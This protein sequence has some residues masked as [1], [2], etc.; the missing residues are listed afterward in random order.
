MSRLILILLPLVLPTYVIRFQIGPLPTT[1]LEVFLLAFLALWTTQRGLPGWKNARTLLQKRGW[2]WPLGLW[3]LAGLIG[4]VVAQ[5]HLAALGL[6][7]AY[8]LEPALVFAMLTDLV[9]DDREKQLLLRSLSVTVAVLALWAIA[10]IAGLLPIPTPW[11]TPPA[12]LRAT[13]P[14]PFPNALALFVVPATALF[15]HLLTRRVNDRH[16]IPLHPLWSVIGFGSGIIATVLAKSD[17][18]LIALGAAMFLSLVFRKKSR[19]LAV[20]LVVIAAAFLLAR[21]S[22]RTELTNQFLFR[23]WSGK[24]RLVMWNET[25]EM[26]KDRPIFGAGLGGY[27]DRILPYHKATWMEIFQYPHT[28]LLNLWSET[29]VLGVAAFG[30]ILALWWKHGRRLAL[31]ILAA[32][33]VHGLVDVPYFKNDLAVMFWMLVALTTV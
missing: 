2:A 33:L 8:F 14:F 29:G 21:P 24:V 6:W 15:F 10:Q 11:D 23:E 12:G 31:P 5:D 7:R 3:L 28:I 17:G 9:R 16:A 18:G 30:W 1:L 27:P 19:W 22:S 26:L 32:I 25:R 20:A 4:V 13:G